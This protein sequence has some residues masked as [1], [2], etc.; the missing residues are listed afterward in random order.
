MSLIQ[1]SLFNELPKI[2]GLN[3]INNFINEAESNYFIKNIDSSEWLTDLKRRTQHYGYKYDYT[4]KN[5]DSS[6]YL[7]ELPN[8]LKPISSKLQSHFGTM[9]NQ[10][11][12]NQYEPG[13]GISAHIDRTDIFK[14][15]IATISLLS[16]I[17]MDF[18]NGE[19]KES[20]I[21]EPQSLLILKK[22]ARYI[23]KHSISP[24]KSDIINGIK[25]SRER[26]ISITFRVAGPREN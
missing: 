10:V 7:G 1:T 21:L 26:R 16:P 12:I 5:I 18:I 8:W 17:I 23:W 6:S 24:R 15:T 22:D 11:I 20:L 14:D 9:P 25:T 13:Q 2:N 4:S 3:Y 19:K